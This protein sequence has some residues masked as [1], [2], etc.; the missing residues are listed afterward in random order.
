M[1]AAIEIAY[2]HAVPILVSASCAALF[3]FAQTLLVQGG[4]CAA[5]PGVIGTAALSASVIH[6]AGIVSGAL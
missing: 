3:T 4:F 5:T 1:K 6:A 2:E